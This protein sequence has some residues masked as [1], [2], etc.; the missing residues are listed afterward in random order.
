MKNIFRKIVLN[1]VQKQCIETP[2][3]SWTLLFLLGVLLII[4]LQ[5]LHGGVLGRFEHVKNIPGRLELKDKNS[6]I[7]NFKKVLNVQDLSNSDGL[8]RRSPSKILKEDYILEDET[9]NVE[10]I[11]TKITE[12]NKLAKNAFLVYCSNKG[13]EDCKH[14]FQKTGT[15]L[16]RKWQKKKIPLIASF[17]IGELRR[18]IDL[19][20]GLRLGERYL[21]SPNAQNF[22]EALFQGL[23]TYESMKS[24]HIYQGFD[25]SNILSDKVSLLNMAKNLLT[26][27][28][29]KPALQ[30]A[31]N[32]DIPWMLPE[33]QRTS[34]T[35]EDS[36]GEGRDSSWYDPIESGFWRR[37][38]VAI[39]DFDTSNYNNQLK[40]SFGEKKFLEVMDIEDPNTSINLEYLS[41]I[42]STGVV[43]KMKVK[44]KGFKMKMKFNI[45][46][47]PTHELTDIADILTSYYRVDWGETRAE[48][49]A[50][51]LAA[52]LGYTV[53]PT[54]YKKRIRLFLEDDGFD[55]ALSATPEGHKEL[56]RR[57]NKAR[58]QMVDELAEEGNSIIPASKK[59][60]KWKYLSFMKNATTVKSRHQEGRYYI[61]MESVS[62][63]FRRQKD[64]DWPVGLFNKHTFG[65]YL[66]REF[67]AFMLF[68]LWLADKDIKDANA[69]LG[70]VKIEP[71]T[72]H[73]GKR[74]VYY[75]ATD[76]GSTLGGL[77]GRN[78]PNYFRYNLV[79]EKDSVLSGPLE[80]QVLVLNSILPIRNPLLQV[81]SFSDIKW[82]LR[83]MAQLTKEQI[84]KSFLTADY[85][86]I[87]A[88]LFTQKLL[89]RRDQLIQALGL[90][91]ED[92]RSY[93]PFPKVLTISGQTSSI[94]DPK[95]YFVSSCKSCFKKGELIAFPEKTKNSNLNW[96]DSMK[97]FPESSQQRK[98]ASILKN[99]LTALGIRVIGRS[100]ERYPIE[101]GISFD[102]VQVS[103]DLFLP[104]RYLLKNPFKK[105]ENRFWLVDIF[106]F[107]LQVGRKQN[108]RKFNLWPNKNRFIAKAGVLETFELIKVTT[109]NDSGALSLKDIL[110]NYHPQN[111]GLPLKRLKQSLV[112]SMKKG[113]LIIS[114]RYLTLGTQVKTLPPLFSLGYGASARGQAS[115]IDR[116]SLLKETET[117]IL[118]TWSDGSHLN[119]DFR[120]SFDY[121]LGEFPFLMARYEKIKDHQHVYRFNLSKD[122]EKSILL[123]NMNRDIPDGIPRKYA[124]ESSNIKQSSKRFLASFFGLTTYYGH[125]KTSEI[126]LSNAEEKLLKELVWAE[127]SF[128][129]TNAAHLSLK[130]TRGIGATAL[131]D[132]LGGKIM[133]RAEINYMRRYAKRKHYMKMVHQFKNL[134][135]PT[136]IQF[137]ADSVNYYLGKLSLDGKIL[138]SNQALKDIL[139]Q[140][141]DQM[142]ACE[143]F[144]RYRRLKLDRDNELSKEDD[145]RRFCRRV[146]EERIS[147]DDIRHKDWKKENEGRKTLFEVWSFMKNLTKAQKKFVKFETIFQKGKNATKEAQEL[148]KAIVNLLEGKGA[149]HMVLMS[150]TSKGNIYRHIEINSTLEGFPGQESHIILH[151]KK[152]G[153]PDLK[154]LAIWNTK[155]PSELLERAMEPALEVLS[156]F[157]YG[158]QI[159]SRFTK[160]GLPGLYFLLYRL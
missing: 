41:P 43:P 81:L 21:N 36:Q 106:R 71:E 91:G 153:N 15:K 160:D 90:D 52:A 51:N 146:V 16:H 12:I 89:Y 46:R 25:M 85:P 68:Y 156:P 148:S 47:P 158:H 48:F 78:R 9:F 137:D 79:N 60:H 67:R 147:F 3:S 45:D 142:R 4:P 152:R 95:S 130:Q 101:L 42:N 97:V 19:S 50:N 111:I 73:G 72:P 122:R 70:L 127:K 87:V 100:L 65:K 76:M 144:G 31:V 86:E 115:M 38:L 63:E 77:L 145:I 74:K 13:Y 39:S 54:Y 58:N 129:K 138:F 64:I 132:C 33:N 141:L 14:E 37:P 124:V 123:S 120:V 5:I 112:E 6:P 56:L 84:K 103:K 143:T 22:L 109:V 133:A 10:A 23:E 99:L 40:E 24:E 34:A 128:S 154:N 98:T 1:Y 17:S 135:P 35:Q 94:K 136:M 121:L 102:G 59:A 30:E 155:R 7:Y 75:S 96:L 32:L 29:I 20:S 114:S 80:K 119:A 108:H 113:D 118:T 83:M 110:K 57:F 26:K 107:S 117:E 116:I 69:K 104:A 131:V 66:K 159:R 53:D 61:E 126:R 55:S 140:G 139:G 82:I 44:Y 93:G 88:E 8:E 18:S 151:K 2:V 125:I 62:L 49:V 105:G 149:T 27:V 134:L 11:Q 28:K 92:L 150:L 157:L